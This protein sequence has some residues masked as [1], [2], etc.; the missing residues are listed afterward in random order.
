MRFLHTSDWHVGR[1]IRSRSRQDEFEAVLDEMVGIVRH[2][3]A[4]VVLVAGDLFDHH[5]PTAASERLVYETLLRF[6]AEGA[7][8]VTI[9]GNHE[10]ASKLAVVSDLLAKLD[11]H[12]VADF[13]RPDRG[14][15]LRLPSRDG[16][17]TAEVGCIPFVPERRFGDAARLFEDSASWPAGYSEGLARVVSSYAEGMEAGTVHVM[18]AHLFAS[19]AKL[20]GSEREVSVGPQYAVAAQELPK[21]LSYLAL[22]H[23]HRPQRVSAA[24]STTWYSG[25]PIQLDFGEEG[26][27]KSMCLVEADPGKPAKVEL[28]PLSSGRQLRTISGTM[29]QVLTAGEQDPRAYLRVEIELE[30]QVPGLADKVREH[31]PNAVQI[32]PRYPSR[33]EEERPELG[34]LS[35]REQLDLFIRYRDGSTQNAAVLDA[36]DEL[37]EEA[38]L[39]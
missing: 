23:I 7:A 4:D 37:V 6:K 9:A 3:R 2:T 35:L 22:G 19:G 17:Q 12:L 25:S 1:T 16:T 5:V 24:P 36:F 18:M 28:V 14:G 20:G 39:K 27:Q 13:R 38:G 15:I 31:L 33:P 26:E 8:V 32:L 10:S 30:E 21:T 34:R 29:E 11:V